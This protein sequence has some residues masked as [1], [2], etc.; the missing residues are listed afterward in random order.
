M[1]IKKVYSDNYQGEIMTLE[2]Y[3]ELRLIMST[4]DFHTHKALTLE[5]NPD[6]FPYMH[7]ILDV[8]DILDDITLEEKLLTEA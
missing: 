5:I 7:Y 3:N 4:A 6:S 8:H 1:K 2:A